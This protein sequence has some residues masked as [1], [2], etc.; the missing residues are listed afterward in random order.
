[1]TVHGMTPKEKHTSK[2]PDVSHFRVFGCIYIR[3]CSRQEEIKT[4]PKKCIFIGY[5]LDQKGYR[6]FN[7]SIRKLQVNRDVLFDEMVS[8]YSPL[9]ITKDGEA[10]IGDVS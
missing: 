8:W 1:M 5:S 7:P 6:C 3:A 4:R 2:K 9:K 10:K